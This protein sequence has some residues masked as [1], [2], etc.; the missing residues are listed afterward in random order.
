MRLLAIALLGLAACGKVVPAP[1]EQ[2]RP[3]ARP[4]VTVDDAPSPSPEPSPAAKEPP[5]LAWRLQ[6]HPFNKGVAVR[7]GY[8]GALGSRRLALAAAKNGK[9]LAERDVCFTFTG[10]FAFLDDKTGALVCEQ[11]VQLLALPELEYQGSRALAG[12]ARAAAFVPGHAAIAFDGG[13]VRVYDTATWAEEESLSAADAITSI[14]LSADGRRLA[15][16]MEGGDVALHERGGA[17][18]RI[19]VKLGLPVDAVAFA[20]AGDRVFCAAGPVAAAYDVATQKEARRWSTVSNV[21]AAAWLDGGAIGS[22][23]DDGLLLLDLAGT[24]T[25]FAGGLDGGDSVVA[26]AAAGDGLFCAAERDGQVACYAEGGVSRAVTIPDNSPDEERASG[27]VLGLVGKRLRV[28]ALPDSELPKAGSYVRLLRYTEA[29]VGDVKSARWI[30][31]TPQAQVLYVKKDVIHVM[32]GSEP[33]LP[34]ADV[35]DPLTY[36]TPVRLAWKRPQPAAEE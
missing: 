10:A 14:A 1:K 29:M 8:V 32:L 6:T 21:K 3:K 11:E 15:L 27:R 17:N 35:N 13:A 26:I 12:L 4:R 31:L 24:A 34:I 18:A 25:S 23:G 30:E 2:P 36:D 5:A 9:L 7:G 20:P 28:K 22:A 16:G 19:V 33:L